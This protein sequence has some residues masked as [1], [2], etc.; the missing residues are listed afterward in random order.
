MPRRGSRTATGTVLPAVAADPGARPGQELGR[1]RRQGQIEWR[2]VQVGAVVAEFD[3][4]RDRESRRAA[5]Q[6]PIGR[7]GGSPQPRLGHPDDLPRAQEHRRRLPVG[8]A[9]DVRADVHPV[10]EVRVEAPGR[11]V[12]GGVAFGPPAEGVRAGVDAAAEVRLQFGD[13]QGHPAVA[14]HRA[15]QQWG[16]LH[17]GSPQQRRV[18]RH[19]VS[20]AARPRTRATSVARCSATRTG[21]VPPCPSRR[22]TDPRMVSTS[23]TSGVRWSEIVCSAA[24]STSCS[25]EF[26]VLRELH[27]GTGDLVGIAER[28]VALDQP[29]RDIRGQR[30]ALRR[31][32]G[33]ALGVH[34]QGRDHAGEGRQEHLERFDRVEDGLLVLL[35]VAVVGQ[36][37]PLERGQQPGEVADQPPALPRASSAMS[38]FFFCGMIEDPVEYA[39]SRVTKPNSFVFHMMISS[40]RRD[41]SMPICAVM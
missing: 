5:R 16:D 14:E 37:E 24:S 27:Q 11:A 29:L 4:E 38:G 40:A 8:R 6:V 25:S 36:R 13:A 18:E 17:G 28:D 3:A 33:H 32:L 1:R 20:A 30:V 23:R 10:A 26:V 41:R 35:Q 34:A 39:S 9:D 19:F 22:S 21:A 31:E 12:H 15:Q 7:G 2:H